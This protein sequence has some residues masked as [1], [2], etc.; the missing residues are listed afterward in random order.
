MG[1]LSTALDR[2]AVALAVSAWV[3]SWAAVL[4]FTTIGARGGGPR[5]FLLL[6]GAVDTLVEVTMVLRDKGSFSLVSCGVWVGAVL[7]LVVVVVE[8]EVEVEDEV[9]VV[10]EEVE[11]VDP[12]PPTPP[13]LPSASEMGMA[14]KHSLSRSEIFK[15]HVYFFAAVISLWLSIFALSLFVFNFCVVIIFIISFINKVFF[16]L[17]YYRL[18]RLF[19]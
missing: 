7:F 3:T 2:K 13:P 4:S 5:A 11:E 18:A 15:G 1:T 19:S 6:P 10:V 9:A 8:D 14:G 12:P 17:L 16:L